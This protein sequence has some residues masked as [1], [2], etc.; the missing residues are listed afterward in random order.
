MLLYLYINVHTVTCYMKF[1]GLM[2][3]ESLL[4]LLCF[5]KWWVSRFF[6]SLWKS[7][8]S[9]A[10]LS[11]NL[12]FLDH[13]FS[14]WWLERLGHMHQPFNNT[15]QRQNTT[16][17]QH[18][19]KITGCK[20]P[21]L[22]VIIISVSWY[23]PWDEGPSL[24]MWNMAVVPDAYFLRVTSLCRRHVLDQPLEQHAICVYSSFSL[25]RCIWLLHSSWT[26]VVTLFLFSQQC[27]AFCCWK[28]PGTT[29]SH[30]LDHCN[31]SVEWQFQWII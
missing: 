13:V 9:L 17:A 31:T 22:Q 18:C 5:I 24:P 2:P 16:S 23:C 20:C 14:C 3:F 1:W 12:V 11:W 30:K 21:W 29:Y 8:R 28:S 19:R 15:K 10:I 4:S 7:P 25:D 27:T 26:T 6:S